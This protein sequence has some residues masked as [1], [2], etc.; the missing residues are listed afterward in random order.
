MTLPRLVSTV[1]AVL[2]LASWIAAAAWTGRTVSSA[3][4]REQKALYAA[5][6]LFF[7]GAGIASWWWP[8]MRERLWPEAALLDWALVAAFLGGLAACWWARLHMGRLWS[9]GVAVKEGHRVVDTGP[10]AIVRH[11]IYTGAFIAVIPFAA[12]R[13][14][15]VDLLFA[16]GFV[17]FFALKAR[18][19]ERFLCAQLGP[20]YER[21]R[22][23]VPMLV[24]R[25]WRRVS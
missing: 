20:D 17:V 16:A 9:G 2:F 12:I 1:I 23:R 5:G 25:P 3:A 18:I 8:G 13:A 24:P 15:P 19:E 14:R 11:P 10:Y 7:G 22:E 21:Y 4:S 6:L